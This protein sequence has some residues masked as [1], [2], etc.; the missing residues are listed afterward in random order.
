MTPEN[1]FTIQ[2]TKIAKKSLK[3]EIFLEVGK[4]HVILSQI[5]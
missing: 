1:C 4:K 5:Y 3:H 2:Q